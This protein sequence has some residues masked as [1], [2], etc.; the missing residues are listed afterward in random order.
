MYFIS[1]CL[2]KKEVEK[3]ILQNKT[4][5]DAI[6]KQPDTISNLPK[7]IPT[8]AKLSPVIVNDILTTNKILTVTDIESKLFNNS[9]RIQVSPNV[10]TFVVKRPVNRTVFKTVSGNRIEI[11]ILEYPQIQAFINLI[12]ERFNIHP[13]FNKYKTTFANT[14]LKATFEALKELDVTQLVIDSLLEQL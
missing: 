5:L 10:T 7:V 14:R 12:A 8:V 3:Q 13:S 2:I 1:S 11:P 4:Y 6:V 9:Q